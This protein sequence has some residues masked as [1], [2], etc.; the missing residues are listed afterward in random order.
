M[1]VPNQ[2]ANVT[3]SIP[4]S[5]L[6]ANFNTP[7]TLGNTAI[8]LGN[9]VTTLNN[10][11]LANVTVSSGNVTVTNVSITTANVT[12]LITGNAA[13]TGGA[14]NGTTLGATTA[15]TANVTTLT[16][17]STVTINGGTANQVQYLDGSK[18]L[19]GS[20]NLTFNGTT[21]SAAGLSDSG[22]LT[23]T[24]TG[25][26]ILGDFSNATLA[27]RVMFQ[28]STTNSAT[29]VFAIPNGTSQ[30]ANFSAVNNSDPTNAS[31][32]QIA[33]LSADIRFSSAITGT[34]TYLP[35]TFYTGGSERMR[36]DASGNL[37][38]GS[39][40]VNSRRLTINTSGQTDLSIVAASNNY[41]QL[42]FG[43]T[44]ADSKGIIAYYNSDNSMQFYTN[45]TERARITSGGDFLVGQT[46]AS[47]TTVG[48][49][50]KAN[51]EVSGC[52]AASTNG[53]GTQWN[54]YSTGAGAYRFY[55]GMGGTI[56][57]TS[58]TITAISDV[59]LKENIQDLDVG[60]NAV[61]ALKPRKFDWK[62]GKGKDKKGDRGWIAQEFEQVFP[63]M[64]DTWK[65]EP[66]EGEEPYKAVNADLIP[67][68]VKAIQ[69]LK[70]E[71]D[72][73]KAEVAAL[74]GTA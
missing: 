31:A 53:G 45:S 56:F 28:T 72:A 12:N 30:I 66:P 36:L 44:G 63:D 71:L 55:V 2:F 68:L 67:V 14:I 48:F 40:P 62:A 4:L 59:R 39:T 43:Y 7:I 64:I 15:S 23:F 11:T 19:V 47:Q 33:S 17:S 9:T 20:A 1:P 26:R 18:A 58:T 74:K 41:A 3:T 60:L 35:M 25:N 70:A 42:L 5:Q 50:A 57:A 38:I 37:G 65:D 13:I 73:T 52:Q 49:F 34:G 6:D 27:N 54:T 16:T 10:M 22:N 21:L 61:M 46:S 69:E 29:A 8:Q 32:A 51:A 24:G